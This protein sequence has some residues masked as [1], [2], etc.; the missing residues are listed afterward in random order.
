MAVMVDQAEPQLMAA[1]ADHLLLVKAMQVQH[2][3]QLLDLQAVVVELVQQD[4]E[5]LPQPVEQVEMD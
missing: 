4:L 3:A 2:P 5:Y 1:Q